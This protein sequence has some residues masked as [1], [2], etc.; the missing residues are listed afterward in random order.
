MSS[1]SISSVRKRITILWI[2]K[3]KLL[4]SMSL[5]SGWV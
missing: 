5:S 4:K 1:L 2:S 3:G